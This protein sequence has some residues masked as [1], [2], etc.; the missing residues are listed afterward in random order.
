MLTLQLNGRPI[1]TLNTSYGCQTLSGGKHFEEA[2]D[3][4]LDAT[5]NQYPDHPPLVAAC[6]D[7]MKP[8]QP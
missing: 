3:N 8:L 5:Q 2:V 7:P 4:L 6:S 1:L